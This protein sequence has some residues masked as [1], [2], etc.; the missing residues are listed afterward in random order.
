VQLLLMPAQLDL[1]DCGVLAGAPVLEAQ[2]L[3]LATSPLIS[4]LSITED[5]AALTAA[6]AAAL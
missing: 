2:L 5:V 4:H 1:A 6:A 3:F